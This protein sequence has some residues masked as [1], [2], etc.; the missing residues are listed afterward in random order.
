MG[1]KHRCELKTRLYQKLFSLSIRN[2]NYILYEKKFL[3]FIN[4]INDN[5]RHSKTMYQTRLS[6]S[7]LVPPLNLHKTHRVIQMQLK[8]VSPPLLQQKLKI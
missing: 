5:Q 6:F 8:Q 2:F 3:P 7:G 1:V 4:E